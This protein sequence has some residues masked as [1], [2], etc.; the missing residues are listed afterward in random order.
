VKVLLAKSLKG[1]KF[2]KRF[3]SIFLLMSLASSAQA[4]LCAVDDVPAATLLLPYFEVDMGNPQGVNTVFSIN[5]AS[6]SP[7]LAH[8][9]I[10]TDW[11][12][13]VLDFDVFLTGYDVQTVNLYDVFVRGNLPVTADEQSDLGLDPDLRDG[14]AGSSCLSGVEDS[15][16]PH[17]DHP[18][19]DGSFPQT[20][21][22]GSVDCSII[23]QQFINPLLTGIRL[24]DLQAKLTGQPIDGAC[25]GATH[26]DGH[27]RGYITVDSVDTCS[28][29]F[30]NDPD[31][32][33]DGV[34]P[35][36]AN[37]NNV[38][39]GDFFVVTGDENAAS[40]D[41]LVHIEA[42]DTPNWS[43]GYTFYGRYSVP[44]GTIDGREPLGTTWGLRFLNDPVAV[45]GAG[46]G[47]EKGFDGGTKLYVWRDSTVLD[48]DSA[49]YTCGFPDEAGAG[50]AWAPLN[51]TEV[52][53]FDEQ[54][55]SEELCGFI[56]GD[57][58]PPVSP[59]DVPLD[60]D[61]VCFPLETQC[62]DIEEEP[63]RPSF[64]FGWMFLN[65]NLNDTIA[66]QTIFDLDPGVDGNLA[67][68]YV[69]TVRD[70]LGRF[71]VGLSAIEIS[72]ACDDTNLLIH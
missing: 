69:T 49:G 31:Y 26:L 9:V 55:D 61:P 50:P 6:A 15:C 64:N 33:S 36:I 13:P 5:N 45:A 35:A 38:L 51:E 23:F 52:V 19:W 20:A 14:V 24:D 21:A 27:A 3:F 34:N 47:A 59:P 22:T 8:V 63:L 10:W 37:N 56:F 4:A 42:T 57:G 39:W 16:S 29:L 12:Q 30:Q 65:L 68:S 66:D 46:A 71:S 7:A 72:S 60:E 54:E 25:F 40:G 70:A 41:N 1:K 67:Q 32:F 18:E 44:S 43:T 58:G 2:M 62:V 48:I 17:G 11:S 53:V 28:L